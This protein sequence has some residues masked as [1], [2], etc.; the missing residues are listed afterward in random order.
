MCSNTKLFSDNTLLEADLFSRL[1]WHKDT[2]QSITPKMKWKKSP[3]KQGWFPEET[4][5]L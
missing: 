1:G 5:V 3:M 4:K 2:T